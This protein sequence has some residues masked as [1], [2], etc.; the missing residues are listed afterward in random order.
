[1]HQITQAH[2]ERGR[3]EIKRAIRR[4]DMD[5]AQFFAGIVVHYRIGLGEI[6]VKLKHPAKALRKI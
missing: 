5:K 3:A 4:G 6:Q 2:I 1:M